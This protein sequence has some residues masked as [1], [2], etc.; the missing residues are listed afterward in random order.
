MSGTLIRTKVHP[1]LARELVPRPVPLA[2]LCGGSAR[3]LTLIRAPAGW[4]KSSL[5]S[6]WF[7]ADGATRSFAWLSL[8]SSDN[9]PVRFFMYVI[10][11]LRTVAPTIGDRSQLLLTTSGVGIVDEVL[12]VLINELD[13]LPGA[14]ALVIDDYHLITSPAVHEA[15][16][17]L[18]DHAPTGLELVISTRI[19]P[20]LNVARLRARGELLE[21]AVA[22]LGFSLAEATSLLNEQRGLGL[23]PEDVSLL[24]DRTEGWP[25][26][27]SWPHCRYE[28][29]MTRTTSSPG[30]PGTTATSSTT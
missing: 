28:D 11:A 2:Y 4:G 5:L 3:R 10:E 19:Q 15:V 9:D 14:T 29:A 17:F 30:S 26:G 8:D 25:A 6:T 24:V 18:V 22:E 7:S 16:S 12:P 13:A 23:D 20:P 27:S 1:P 21:I